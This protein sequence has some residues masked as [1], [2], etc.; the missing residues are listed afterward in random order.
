MEFVEEGVVPDLLHIIPV[1]D[2][3]VL[4]WVLKV[5]NTSLGA[6]FVTE[7][8]I[9]VSKIKA[10]FVSWTTNNRWEDRAWTFITSETS[11]ELEE[12][13]TQFWISGYYLI[14]NTTQLIL[15]F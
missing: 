3:T 13:K 10:P 9:R 15:T 5:K 14:F 11:L 7:K 12:Q 6:S 4:N 2:D 1:V 8:D